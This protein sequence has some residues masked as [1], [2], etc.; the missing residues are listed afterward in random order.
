VPQQLDLLDLMQQR[1]TAALKSGALKSIET[2]ERVIE[3]GGVRFI[4]RSVSSLRIKESHS[5]AGPSQN[6]SP[7]QQRNPFLPY[8]PG[9]FVTNVGDTHVCLLNKFNVIPHH[10]LIVT[11][12]YESQ[13]ALLT[14]GDFQAL[15]HCQA[16]IK[17]LCFYNGGTAAGASQRHKHLQIVP[18]PLSASGPGLP[19]EALINSSDMHSARSHKVSTELG[20]PFRHAF[21]RLD[22]SNTGRHS[23]SA[24][25]LY[26]L[27]RSLLS[28]S[29][30]A[31]I[32]SD[33]GNLRTSEAYNLLVTQ[34]WM[35]VVPRE[36]ECDHGISVNALGY[37]GSLFVGDDR[38]LHTI[39]TVGPM[40]ILQN[41]AK[42]I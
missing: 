7:Q 16:S 31:I 33:D 24:S 36:R 37:A 6:S 18:L 10:V 12:R 2:I 20:F 15:W 4:V 35:L 39:E 17:G 3:D 30:I 28:A 27:Y 34:R 13:E 42:A 38:D 26:D 14:R 22:H 8:D 21:V 29:G 1:A 41:V 19:V 40:R 32:A 5:T 11:R 23:E 9:L 25:P